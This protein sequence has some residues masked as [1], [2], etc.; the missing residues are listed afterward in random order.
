MFWENKHH[1]VSLSSRIDYI[2]R[3]ASLSRVSL[4]LA[5]FVL[6]KPKIAVFQSRAE[7]LLPQVKCINP[8]GI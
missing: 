6:I 8:N 3:V 5:G 7:G 2:K 1:P 4:F